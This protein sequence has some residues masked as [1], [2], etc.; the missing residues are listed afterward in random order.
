[1]MEELLGQIVTN[2][3]GCDVGSEEVVFELTNGDCYRMYHE[4]DCCESVS[5][6][7]VVG[8]VSD[9]I[10]S[11]ILMAR[12]DSESGEDGYGSSTWTFYNF[13]TLKGYLTLRWLG[14]SNGYYSEGV[15]FVKI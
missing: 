13:G 6:N 14:E 12:E 3:T 9:L 1:M 10:G 7:E 2:I 15:S 4:Q 11:P 8:N 5:L